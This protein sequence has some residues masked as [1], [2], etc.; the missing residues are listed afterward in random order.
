MLQMWFLY[1]H[2]IIKCVNIWK[3]SVT[4][5]T[6]R[7]FTNVQCRMLQNYTWLNNPFKVQDSKKKDFNV[8]ESEK[9]IDM[10]ADSILPATLLEN[11]LFKIG[12]SSRE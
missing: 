7:Y 2:F 3:M 12:Y 9:F 5:G 10:V 8:R 4:K 6:D 1:V 11:A